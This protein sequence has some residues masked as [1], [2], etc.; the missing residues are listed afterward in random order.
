MK[1]SP[2]LPS[3]LLLALSACAAGDAADVLASSASELSARRS[4]I[5]VHYPAGAGHSITVRG[6]AA[7]LTW[8]AGR[9]T[10]AG[11]E[12]T[13]VLPLDLEASVELKPLYDD[14][15]WAKGPNYALA[16]GQTLDVWPVFFHEGGR[17]E[18]RAR[19]HT[20]Q[21]PDRDVVVYLPPSYDE[22]ARERYP[23]VYMHDAQNLFD[24]AGAFG[25]VAW[26]VAGAMNRGFQ[27]ASIHEAII[28]GL[29]N[30]SARMWEYTPTSGG[31]GG[32]GA[33]RYVDF[34]AHEV[35]PAIDRDFRTFPEREHTG[36]I[37]SSLGG[38]VSAFAGITQADT[39][40]LVGAVSP[41]TWWDGRWIV[42]QV[43]S[44]ATLPMRVYVDSGDSGP[45]RD[46]VINTAELA[47]AY[48]ERGADLRYV[49]QPGASH[50]ERWWRERLPSALGFL[51]GG[52]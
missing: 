49:V 32:G 50:N 6:A 37:G 44:A 41:S 29:D 11:A 24:D 12:D 36:V 34:V 18:R 43:R 28:I 46:D 42:G 9:P 17:L 16:P 3:L 10:A 31:G 2:S 20:E 4:T 27:G 19:W 25:G 51:L 21:L 5:I 45:S 7:G 15:T 35:K 23:V 48:R 30:T 39:F 8:W 13:W 38:L 22:N 47:R 52:R 40:G 33:S 14:A 26:D 1:L